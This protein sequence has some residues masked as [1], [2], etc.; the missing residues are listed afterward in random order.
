MLLK[1]QVWYIPFYIQ[2]FVA[3]DACV[4]WGSQVF[5][6]QW[7]SKEFSCL[8][9]YKLCQDIIQSTTK[10]FSAYCISTSYCCC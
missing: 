3:L 8:Y 7:L 9:W 5:E 1:R 2:R 4:I 10:Y 6:T